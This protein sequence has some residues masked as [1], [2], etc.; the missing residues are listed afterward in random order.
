MSK[1]IIELLKKDDNKKYLYGAGSVAKSILLFCDNNGIRIDGIV[2]DKDYLKPELKL[3]RFDVKAIEDIIGE[4]DNISVI[5][6]NAEYLRVCKKCKELGFGSVYYLTP[7]V[8][9]R[10]GKIFTR[11]EVSSKNDEIEWLKDNL[12]DDCSR[13]NLDLFFDGITTG[14]AKSIMEHYTGND[15]FL[16]DVYSLS[17]DE[18]FCDIGAY[19]GDTILDFTDAVNNKFRQIYDFEVDN[20]IFAKSKSVAEKINPHKIVVYNKCLWSERKELSFDHSGNET[21]EECIVSTEKKEQIVMAERLDD[22]LIDREK[23]S[24]MKINFSGST[25][26]IKGSEKIIMEDMPRIA[27]TVGFGFDDLIG[28]PRELLRISSGKYKLF[29]RY[30]FPMTD[31]LVLYAYQA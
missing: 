1:R 5:A 23:V 20:E 10:I 7:I 19:T 22:V 18:V 30:R 3:D 14:D 25:E 31:G 9:G 27:C 11:E 6:A 15:Y 13:K 12:A 26:V 2:V 16:N 24:L 21:D 28:V 17:N 8:Y 29:L 4:K